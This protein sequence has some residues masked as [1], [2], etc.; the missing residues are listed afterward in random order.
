[1]PFVKM[2]VEAREQAP[3]SSG[4]QKAGIPSK[5]PCV[6]GS[7]VRVPYFLKLSCAESWNPGHNE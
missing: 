3:P 7:E 2:G 6:E 1:M 4:I 5:D